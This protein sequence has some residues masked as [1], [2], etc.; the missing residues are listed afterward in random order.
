MRGKGKG[1]KTQSF[2]KKA[3]IFQGGREKILFRGEK[4][5][6]CDGGRSIFPLGGKKHLSRKGVVYD[7]PKRRGENNSKEE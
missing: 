6:E 2:G 5:A 4:M 1:E 3:Y 7:G